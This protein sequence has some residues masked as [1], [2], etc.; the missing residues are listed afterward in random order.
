MKRGNAGASL[1]ESINRTRKFFYDRRH[2][3]EWNEGE[4]EALIQQAIERGM[5]R[6]VPA[7]YGEFP[8]YQTRHQPQI[9]MPWRTVRH[10][11]GG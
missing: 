4:R 10:S 7:G 6:K 9:S 8:T 3:V 5:V 11:E 1:R 2:A